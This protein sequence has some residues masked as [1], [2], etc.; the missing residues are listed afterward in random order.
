MSR[1]FRRLRLPTMCRADGTRASAA[2]PGTGGRAGALARPAR[3][4]AALV[5]AFAALLALPLQAQA[6][7]LVS[8]LNVSSSDND[9]KGPVGG[10]GTAAVAQKFTIPEGTDYFL[11]DV[12]VNVDTKGDQAMVMTIRNPNSLGSSP[13]RIV[14][15]LNP[16]ASPG[17]GWETYTAPSGAVLEDGRSYFVMLTASSGGTASKVKAVFKDDDS[18]LEGWSIANGM[19]RRANGRWNIATTVVLRMRLRGREV[20]NNANLSALALERLNGTAITLDPVFSSSR[21]NYTASVPNGVSSVNLIATKAQSGATAVIENDNNTTTPFTARLS[22][23]VGSNTLRVTVTAET[24]REKNYRVVVTRAQPPNIPATGAPAITGV[25]Q[26]GKVLTA[27]LGTIADSDG[28]PS[29]S[30]NF[31]YQ[32]VRVDADGFSNPRN[33]GTNSPTY[34]PVAGDAGKK[35]VVKVSFNDDRGYAEGP[36]SSFAYP[37]SGTV[38]AP[39]GACPADSDWCS[40]LT[41]GYLDSVIINHY[42]F[43]DPVSGVNFSQIPGDDLDDKTIDYGDTTWLIGAI[44]TDIFIF[45]GT[46]VLRI[47]LSAYLPRGSV[48]NVGGTTFTADATSELI[49]TGHYLWPLP[50]GFAWVVGQDVTV[51]VKVENFV[52]T[53]APGVSGTAQVGEELTATTAGISDGDGT[54]RAEAGDTGYAYAWQWIRVDGSTETD[55]S[56]ETSKTYTLVAADDGKNVKVKAVSFKDDRDNAEGPL[57]SEAYPSSG[58]ITPVTANN[59]PVFTDGTSQTRTLA[60][61]VG[62]AT[63]SAA[64]NI[65]AAVAATDDDSA[66]TLAYALDG[67]D[68][69]KFTFDTA[70]GRIKTKVGEQYDY[71]EQSSY[72]VTVTVTDDT[73]TVSAAVTINV[74]N[75]TGE[76]PVAPDPPTVDATAGSWTSL[77]VSWDPPDNDGRPV[78][79]SYDLQYKKSVD[80]IWTAGPQDVTTPSTSIPGLE[81]ETAYD[82]QV[83]AT[84]EDGDSAWSTSGTGTTNEEDNVAPVFDDGTS[85]TRLVDETIGDATVAAAANIGNVVEASDADAGDTLTYDLGGTDKDR[86][87]IDA[88]N[89]QIRTKAGE[90][91]DYETQQSYAVIVTVNDGNGGTASI[92]V[93]INV[94]DLSEPPLATAAPTVASRSSIALNVSWNP[95]A[96]QTGRPAATNYDLRYKVQGTS[97]WTDGPQDVLRTSASISGLVAGTSYDVQVR[98]INADDIS[99]W[100]PAGTGTPANAPATG[101]PEISGIIEAGEVLTAT[102]SDIV[103]LDGTTKAEDGDAGFAYTY[104]WVRVDGSTESDIAGAT[105]STYTLVGADE[106]KGIRVRVSFTDDADGPETVTSDAYHAVRILPAPRLPSVDDPNAIWMATLTVADLGSNQYGYDGSQGG[107]TD[108]AFT[109]LGDDTPLSGGTYREVGTLYTIDELFYHTGTDQLL[110][111]L[112]GAFVGGSA[113][114]IFVDVG[115]TRQSFSQANPAS[116]TYTFPSFPNPSW[117]AGDEVTVKI[118]VLAETNGPE[119]LAATSAESA[120]SDDQFDVMLGWDAPAGGGTVTGYRVEQ[121]PDPALQWRT[122]ESSQS[123]TTYADSGLGRGTVRYYRVAALRSGGA[124]YSEIVR[125]QAASETTEIPEQV[126][127]VDVKPA[128]GSDTAL[129]V[130]W[131]RPRTPL[132]RAPATGYHVQYAQH[133]GAAPAVRDGED[134]ARSRSRGGWRGCPGGRGRG[135]S[136]QSS[137]RKARSVRRI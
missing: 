65:G 54:T 96:N 8:N 95:P 123:G 112:D 11:S 51:S 5:V 7:D 50:A 18:G 30:G 39:K 34:T 25:P 15:T 93:T 82:V 83:R 76:T 40:T 74:T 23:D 101:K 66:D 132:S 52:P 14:H 49:G 68:K 47:T 44:N 60:E 125:V 16:P 92:D 61:T 32:W 91:Y 98:A 73:V 3:C 79:E 37:S 109:Y 53:G 135:W 70:S 110:L 115:G 90:S 28:L 107:L 84:N 97:G 120:E 94:G 116:N 136:R 78:I 129:E 133:D 69:D 126:N 26:A 114:N 55:I 12:T 75:N 35:I 38:L 19:L 41:A 46:D 117:S 63:V 104:Q 29:G 67:A 1:F 102:T 100:S 9:F 4:A 77:D 118:V 43:A 122:L 57:T 20:S 88:T 108:T 62:N 58:T 99:G 134:W 59:L 13:G 36:L 80:T 17:T 22:L 128:A 48:F 131:N 33:R 106:G 21:S 64:A 105:G 121:Q 130:A 113:A 42:G 2:I 85:T 137:S 119:N 111:S 6:V 45:G 86:F 103:D 89:G 87:T 127:H 27:G 81:A 71:E 72:S 24:G 124:S 10:D 56:G 31:T